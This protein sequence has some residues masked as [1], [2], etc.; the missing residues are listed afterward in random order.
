MESRGLAFKGLGVLRR[1]GQS[2][3]QQAG[4]TVQPVVAEQYRRLK[5]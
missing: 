2:W 4:L 3:Q 5:N 1:T